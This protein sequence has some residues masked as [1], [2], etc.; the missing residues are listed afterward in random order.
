MSNKDVT[1]ALLSSAQVGFENILFEL[2]SILETYLDKLNED[3]T[4]EPDKVTE[5]AR[6]LARTVEYKHEQLLA[7]AAHCDAYEACRCVL[8]GRRKK[9]EQ[10][11]DDDEN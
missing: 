5:T 10:E 11:G 6:L 4:P 2:K 3:D 7:L 9:K 1:A 8:D